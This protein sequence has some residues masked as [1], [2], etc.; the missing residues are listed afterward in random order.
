MELDVVLGRGRCGAGR[1]VGEEGD[2][3]EEVEGLG[4]G[5]VEPRERVAPPLRPAARRRR[6]RLRR[7]R[8]LHFCSTTRNGSRFRRRK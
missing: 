4:D 8:D 3:V 5:Q 1:E 6:R 7:R 2:E